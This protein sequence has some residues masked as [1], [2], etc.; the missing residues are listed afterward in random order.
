M[1]AWR[2]SILYCDES[3]TF[4]YNQQ[5]CG[6]YLVIMMDSDPKDKGSDTASI[7][8]NV[9]S[10][11]SIF[12]SCDRQSCRKFW[13]GFNSYWR[14]TTLFFAVAFYL[15]FG[16]I[17]FSAVEGSNEQMRIQQ[18]QKD[19]INA[20]NNLTEL[21]MNLTNMTE[22]EARN[23]TFALVILGEIASRSIPAELNPIWDYSSAFFFSSTVITTI[24]ESE[25]T[26]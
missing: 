4:R 10:T 11:V 1:R 14:L 17:I 3:L 13:C 16:G 22:E 15:T 18:V 20:F 21:L 5:F 7:D 12:C 9:S 23:A 8:S 25:N 2:I 19:R 26:M 24:G 6:K